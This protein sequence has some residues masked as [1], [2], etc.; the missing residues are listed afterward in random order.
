MNARV[1]KM[2]ALFESPPGL[3]SML[4]LGPLAIYGT[5]VNHYHMYLNIF[6]KFVENNVPINQQ[7]G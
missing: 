2:W 5:S 7:K 1:G 4:G 6:I 3:L